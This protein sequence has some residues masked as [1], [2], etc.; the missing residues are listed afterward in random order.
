MSSTERPRSVP[1]AL[2]FVSAC[3]TLTI[4]SVTLLPSELHWITPITFL[5]EFSL[6]LFLLY[7]SLSYLHV[8]Q[9]HT[10]RL[11]FIFYQDRKGSLLLIVLSALWALYVFALACLSLIDLMLPGGKWWG[12]KSLGVLGTLFQF[13]FVLSSPFVFVGIFG[14]LLT[15]AAKALWRI[16]A[17]SERLAPAREVPLVV[18]DND[19]EDEGEWDVWKG[20]SG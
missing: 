8:C 16:S 14:W 1:K 5:L 10:K 7:R 20:N 13:V 12:N 6:V 2:M 4:W 15:T 17:P 18:D 11:D 19:V 3:T 9:R